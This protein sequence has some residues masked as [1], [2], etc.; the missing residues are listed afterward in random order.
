MNMLSGKVELEG[1][2]GF[3]CGRRTEYSIRVREANSRS[4]FGREYFGICQEDWQADNTV[5][6]SSLWFILLVLPMMW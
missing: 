4:M 3:I 1:F 6:A 2:T 5:E